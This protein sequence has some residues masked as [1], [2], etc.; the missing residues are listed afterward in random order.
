MRLRP[1]DNHQETSRGLGPPAT[2]GTFNVWR[3]C[4]WYVTR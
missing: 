4:Y 2:V 1:I 3:P